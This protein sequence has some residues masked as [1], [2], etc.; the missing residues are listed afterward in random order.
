M[1]IGKTNAGGGVSSGATLTIT[2]VA[3]A[4]VTASK[5][6]KTYTRT[7]NNS[8]TAVFK[9]LS[10]G[11]WTVTMSG[12]GQSTTRTVE[13]TAD[14]SLT[15]AYFSATITITYPAN[16]T[17]V[18][19]DS[20]GATIASDTNTGTSAKTWTATVGA[21]GTYTITATATDGSGKSKSTT[22]SITAEG[23]VETV[24]LG[25]ALEVYNAGTFGTDSSGTKF[26]AGAR[27][28]YNSITQNQNSL[29]WWCDANTNNLFYIS[30]SID[31]SGY[32]TLKMEI[33][34]ANMNG[35]GQFGL[36]SGNTQDTSD[37][38]AKTSFDSFSGAKALS[39]DISK[40]TSAK[41][42]IKLTQKGNDGADTTATIARIWLE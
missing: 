30:P 31:P 42:Y 20:S 9:G 10:T 38:V 8:G 1:A 25:F 15:I 24:T 41:Y 33:T 12:G 17:C 26:S 13:I 21:T 14:Y 22:V 6:G 27:A 7:I 3:G 37:Y 23:Q 16:S 36:A 35:A 4:T 34:A 2:G 40:V 29:D 5:N 19:T 32:S 39:V 18:V 28:N 11:I